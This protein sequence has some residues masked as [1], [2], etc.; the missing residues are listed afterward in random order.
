[1]S[2][3]KDVSR[4]T[5]TDAVMDQQE[6]LLGRIMDAGQ[7]EVSA[8]A[9][10]AETEAEAKKESTPNG[11][12]KEGQEPRRGGAGKG[13][14]TPVFVYLAVLFAAAF[15]LLLLAYFVQQRN[16]AD[17]I[18]DLRTSM[19]ATREELME[20]NRQLQEEKDA[21]ETEREELKTGLDS[22]QNKY[23]DLN[24]QYDQAQGNITELEQAATRWSN[25]WT[26]E[27]NFQAQDYEAC[28]GFFKTPNMSSTLLPPSGTE[29][30]V[31]EIY[32]A[33]LDMKYLSEDETQAGWSI[34]REET[35]PGR[36]AHG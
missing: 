23:N 29:E 32:Q 20:Q 8:G 21:L 36:T 10:G 1:M 24:E 33:L 11:T 35:F 9:P 34:W 5:L 30:R 18:D 17:A 12:A 14:T 26:L 3:K 15:L 2:E 31:D 25:F 6:D 28:A 7:P 4:E 16:S 27:Q 22:L 19:T 13:K